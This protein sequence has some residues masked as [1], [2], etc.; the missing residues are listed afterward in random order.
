MQSN[1]LVRGGVYLASAYH[2]QG[3]VELRVTNEPLASWRE[4]GRVYPM[5]LAVALVYT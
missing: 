5:R 3:K 4:S 1:V 2:V